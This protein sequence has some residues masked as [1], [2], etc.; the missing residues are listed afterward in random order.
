MLFLNLQLKVIQTILIAVISLSQS[1]LSLILHLFII[2]LGIISL[3]ISSTI[4]KINYHNELFVFFYIHTFIY[5]N[6]TLYDIFLHFLYIFCILH[7]IFHKKNK[8]MYINL[9]II[10]FLILFLSNIIYICY[11]RS[12]GQYISLKKYLFIV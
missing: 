7:Y 1:L 9:Y 8:M 3:Y 2:L 11:Y 10:L 5:H 4:I 12:F 6:I